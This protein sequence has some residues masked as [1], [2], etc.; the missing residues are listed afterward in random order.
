M[1]GCRLMPGW[2]SGARTRSVVLNSMALLIWIKIRRCSMEIPAN[3]PKS[4][5]LIECLRMEKVID[6]ALNEANKRRAAY[7][8]QKIMDELLK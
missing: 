4:D 1:N 8:D 2:T 5:G 3:V 6:D 7:Y